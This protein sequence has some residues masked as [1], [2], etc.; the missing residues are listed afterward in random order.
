MKKITFIR[1]L[2]FL[3][4][5]FSTTIS[6]SQVVYPMTSLLTE[7]VC[8]VS[9][10]CGAQSMIT[11]GAFIGN[12]NGSKILNCIS[13]PSYANYGIINPNDVWIFIDMEKNGNKHDLFVQFN[14]FVNDLPT[15]SGNIYT[16][17]YDSTGG[18]ETG[19]YKAIKINYN[20]GD[21]FELKN[22]FVSWNSNDNSTPQCNGTGYSQCYADVPNITVDAPLKTDFTYTRNCNNIIVTT[23]ITGGK[24]Y[25]TGGLTPIQSPY[26]IKINYGDGTGDIIVAPSPDLYDDPNEKFIN[27]V[28]ASHSFPVNNTVNPINYTITLTATDTATPTPASSVKTSTVT[29]YP[30]LTGLTLTPL[31]TSCNG[32]LGSITASGVTGGYGSYTYSINAGTNYQADATFNNLP[33]GT[34]TVIAKDGNG[35]TISTSTSVVVS[36]GPTASIS[37][38]TNIDCFGNSNGSVTVAGANGTAPYTYAK[39]GITFGSSGTFGS[40]TAG[41]YTITVKDANGCTKTQ[42]VTITEP[43]AALTATVA[44][45]NVTCNGANDGTITITAPTGG[46]GTYEYRLDTG[47]WQTSGNFSA[48]ANA[49]Y[50]VQI[51]DAA[52]PTCIIVLGDQ[53]ITQP[54]ALTATIA[55]TNVT[56]NGANDGTITITAPTGGYGTYEYRLDAGAWQTSGNFSALANATYSVQIRDAANPTCIIVLGDQIIT[57]P[58]ALTATIAKTNVTCNGANDGTITVTAPTGGYGTYEYRLDAGAWQTSG[59]F[60]ALANATYSVQIRD[61]ANPTCIIVLGDQI[62][63]QP[64]ALTA[65]VAKTNVTCNGANDGTISVTAPTGGYGTY[66]YRL[67]TGAWQTSGSFSALANATYSVQ[68]RDAA[69]PTCVIVLGDQIITQPDALTATVAKTNVTCNGANNGTITVTAP[70]GGYGTYEYRLDAGAWQTSGNFTALANATYSVQIRDAANPTCVIVLGDQIITQPD[71]LTATVAKTNVTC[72]GA[73]NGTITITAPTGG[74]GTYEYRLDT[75]A[76]QTS[77]NFSALANATYSVQIRDAANPTCIIVLGD[78]IITQP[79][80]LTA[81]VA[82]TNVTCNGANDGTITIT[83]PTGGYGTYEYRLD[84]GAWQT[85]GNFSALANAT[86]S[87]QIRD[88]ANPTCIIVLGD[89]IITQPDALTATIA[90]TNVTCN[91]ANDGTITITAPTGGYGTYEYRLDTGA[92]QTS[93][94]FSA[95]AN[96]TYSV[97]IRDAAN[98]TCVI[99]LGDQEITQPDAL[100]ATVAKT[101]VTCNGANNGTITV[102]APTGG[103]GTYEYRLDAGAWQTSGNFSALANATYSVQIRDAA[104]PT[105][106]IVLGDQIITQP[107]ALTATVA[108]T[109]VT[110]NGANDGTISVTAPTGG[111]GTYEY[112]LDTGAWQTSGNFSALANAT[113]SVQIRD[114]ANPT[115]IIVLGDQIITQPDALTATVA[116]T[117]VTCNGA[118]NGTITVTAPTGG[119]GTYEYRLDAGAWQTSGNFTALANATYSVQIRDAANPTCVIVLGD[120]IITQPD[121]LTATIAKTNVTCNGANDGTITVTAPTGGYGTYEYRLDAGAWQTSGNFSA[122]ANATYSVQIRD[123]ANPTCIIVLGDQIITQPDALTATVAKTNVTCNGANDGTISVTAPTGGYGTYEYRLDTGAWQ[124]SGSFSA[125]ANATYSV[126]IRDAANPT[127]VIVLGDQIITQPD[128]LTATVAK[129]NVTCNGANNGTITVTA[130]TG[131]Y[132]TYEYRLDAG[133]WQT[134]GNFTALANA[135]YSVQIRDAANPT[136]VIV[137]GDQIITQPDALTATVAKTNVTCNGANNGTITITAPTGGYGTYEYRLDTGAWQTSGNFSALANATYSVQIRDAANPTCII[138]LG[139]QIITQPDALTATV[140]KTNVTCNGANDGTITITAP[141]GGYGTYEYR[142][143]A[144]AWQTSGN[145]SALANATYSVQIRDAANPTCIIVLGDQI[146]TQPDALTATIAKTNVTCN[147]ANDGTITITAPTGGYG[148]YEYRLD[149]G[150]WQTSGNF[151]ALANATYSVQ[152]RDAAN[153]TCVIVLGDQEITQPDALTAT[154]AKTNVTCNGANNGTITVTAPTGGY[155]T[156]EYR[157]D[158]GAWQTSGNFSALANA[159]YSVQIR[160]A[161][162]PTCIIVLGDQI[163]TQPDALTA[164]IAKTNVT[165]NGANNGTITVTAPTGGYGTYE[166]RLDTGAWQTSG[167][168]S[169]LANATYSVQIRDAANPT[170]IIVLGDQIITQPDALTATVAKTNVTCNGANDGTITITAPTGG[171][172]TYEYRLDAGAWQTSGNFSALAN[173]TYSVQIRDAANPTCIIVLGDQIITQPDAL[174]ATIA[175]TNVTCNGANDGTIT[176]TAPTGGYGTYEYRLDTGAWQTSGNFSALANA[177]YSVQIRDAANPTCIIVLGD[178]IITQP[179]ALTATIA[180]TNVTC[181]GA[182]DGTITI[183]APTGGYGTYEYRLD[184]GAWQTSGNFSALANATYS[185]QI[186]DAANPTCIIVLGD[187]IITQPDALTATIAKTNVTCNGANNGTITVTAP[188]GGYG[189]YEYRLDAGAWQTSGNFSALANATY[190]VQIRDAAN[191]TCIIVLGDQIITQPDALTATVAKTNVTCNGANDG[192]ISV[193]APTG[194]YGTYEYRLDTG[195]WQ[196]SGSFSAL[197]NATYSVQIRDAA[198]PTC[199]IV[200]GDQIITQPD[201]LT[202][203]VAKTNVTCNGANN[204]TITVT[205]PTGGYGTYEYRLD[206][207]AWQTSGNFSALANAT[208]SVQIRDA[209]NP[210]CIIVL[211]D[212][213]ITQPDALTA[214][215]AKTN[216]TCNGANDGTITITAP[217]GGYGTYEYRLDAGAWQTSGN[218]SALANATYS[219]QIRDAANPTCIIVLG[220]Q[221]ITQPDALT[222]TV[223]KTNVTCNGANDGTITITAPTGGYGTYEYRL[224]TGAWQTSGN[225]S[226]LANATYSVQIRDAANPTCVIVLGDQEITQPDALT[227]TVAKTNVTCNGANNGTITVTAPTGGYGTYEYRL[228]AGA[229]Q[230]SGNFSALANATYSVQIRDAANPTCII[231][232]G[233]QII[234]QPDALTATVAKTNVTCNG[235]NDGTISV[236][237]PTGG[238]GTYEYRL[239]T[240]AWQTSGNFSALANATY[241]VQIRDAAN[242]TCI[243][244]LGDQI[245][246]QP[247]ALTATVAK[248]NVTCNGANNGTITVT[249]PTGGYGTYEYRLDAGAWQTSGNFSALANATYSVQIR[250]AANP[251]CII[252]LGDQIITQPDAL[253]ATIAKTNVTCNGANNGTI[254]VTAPTGGYGTYEYRLDAGAWQTSGNFSALANA[255]YSVQIRDAANPTCIIVLGDQIIT[256][257]DAL[258]ATVAKTNVTCNGANDGT[259]SVTAPTGGYGTYEYRLDTGAWQTSGSFS[260]LANATYSVQIRDAA[261][262]TCVI[263]LGDQIITQPDALTATVA[264]T[265]V[266]CNGANNGTITVTAPTGGYGTYEYRLDAGAWQTSGNFTAL[267]NAT[268]SVQI[269]DAANPTCVIVLGDQIITQPDALT[270]TVAKTNVTCNGANNG[271]ITITA[272]TGGYGTYEYRLDTGAWQTSGNFSALANA[273]YSVQIRDAANPT[274]IIVLGDQIITQPDALTATVAK[275]NVTCNGANDGTITITAPTG[276]YG[277]YE[278]RLDAGAWQTSGNF[279]ALANATYSVQIRDA[280]NPTCII[281]LGDQIITQPD[282]LTATIAKTNVTCNGANDG[283]ITITAPTGGYGTY[284]YRLDTGAWQ[285]SGNFSALANAT[286]SVQIRDAANPT[287]VIVLGDQIIT[288]PDALTATVAKTNVTCNGAN[289]GTISVTAPA[290][291]YGTYEYRL[292]AGAWQTSGNFSA[293]ANATYSVQIRDAANPTCI[294][295]LGDQEITQANATEPIIPEPIC[296]TDRTSTI[297]LNSYLPTGTPLT[298]SWTNDRNI[299]LSDSEFKPYNLAVGEYNFEY[300]VMIESCPITYFVKITII[301]QDCG[302]VLGCGAIEVHNAFTPNNDGINDSF[303]IDNIEDVECYPENTVEIYNRWGVLVFETKNYN[304]TTNSFNGISRGRTTISQSS[305]L[306]T[307]TYYYILN[308]TSVDTLGKIQTNKKDG[309][310]YLTR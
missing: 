129:T 165:C 89:Q 175:K 1:F 147:G 201:A 273:T 45:T 67:D 192:T 120:Q 71:A 263:V 19:Y 132:G 13:D 116:K 206:T 5:L 307:G 241:S 253:T 282:A 240:G 118:N 170:C 9:T 235:A 250:D 272:P 196:T 12:G 191:P 48:L 190:S 65:T 158:A 127:C 290:G 264:K 215:V 157:L 197:A 214:T 100:T 117:N 2:A 308:Y 195:A 274:C 96:A 200:L 266:T 79:D 276:G 275:T 31:P 232:L 182:N 216:V 219:V 203:T 133:A 146:I 68:I 220:D 183:T 122:L 229:W 94:N 6:Y 110:C 218:F 154:V 304:N 28:F 149:T 63:T 35:C 22:I 113:Y 181:N 50:S 90:K 231:V 98:P 99:V 64:D 72:N 141:T 30:Q 44:K 211:G 217:T 145:F 20:C 281:V 249:A 294:I 10:N 52:N 29:I 296:N 153:P 261:N 131:G 150:A 80:A 284:E 142:L 271:T 32:S 148:T 49:T 288:Q 46:Y 254:T 174:T 69:N 82:K 303:E 61:A 257:P 202:A 14:I 189:T 278:Y 42:A 289:D 260:A 301:N 3:I 243:I 107:D 204:G 62:I 121:A 164:T 15:N 106:I 16:A 130:P 279:S 224:D 222:A 7:S 66:E 85:S 267:A 207:G 178:Q 27:Y 11:K 198:N 225:F 70:T 57:Q 223:A 115:C 239:D 199:V 270:A 291:G 86:Y 135:T 297:S 134:S 17:F 285:T 103:Y 137:L 125:L 205:A 268:Y 88:A 188:T 262:P 293:L 187:Q 236:T 242:P 8:P 76:W 124:T 114:A 176:I 97:Q 37:S 102:T 24:L 244:V 47:A 247:D 299:V 87:V 255:T 309:Y 298:G 105:C 246:T 172:G 91:G 248:T 186:R 209:A 265:N 286:Y 295:V 160:D 179:D 51:R 21:K 233:D 163:I 168:F 283:T 55:K 140:A 123:A 112:R 93:G 119:Y 83:A 161:A 234:T 173:A 210:T 302:I 43:A 138:V 92:W 212:Q 251:T 108:K 167:N 144:G 310:L 77:G 193:T 277:T 226:A 33:S 39:D 143:D 221:I 53:I 74:Y 159:T 81:T 95:L 40:L 194:G 18:L 152:I 237:A 101:N 139:D 269:R 245:I 306:P 259:I 73:N 180:K 280:A 151:S 177:T 128:A 166:Y 36:T 75:G 156:Y 59:N 78:Q 213:I 171:Y 300:Q 258:T 256:Q 25:Q 109:N 136:C 185:V 126:Q 228:D 104:N 34:Y 230:T 58:D 169:A 26:S 292:D 305:G 4:L 252:V 184:A 60:S 227:A 287:C 208:Y 111:Y 56:C 162:N 84:A 23:D 54:D 41:S 155:G 238:Y 38:Q